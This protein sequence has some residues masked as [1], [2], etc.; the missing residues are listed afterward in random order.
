MSLK[1]GILSAIGNT[2]LVKLVKLGDKYPFT[3]YGKLELLNPGG[4]SKDRPA[5]RMIRYG[6]E[7]GQIKP[8]TVIVESSSGNMAISLA[9]ICAYINL[10]LICV[11]D[12]K[13][14][15]QN[16]KIMEAYG[17]K[18]EYV[19]APDPETGE[20]L[21]ARINRVKKLLQEIEGSYWPN[22]YENTHNASSHYHTTMREIA[23]ELMPVDYLFCAVSTCGTIRGCAEYVRDHGMWTQVVGV[24]AAGS[25]IFGGPQAKRMI[26]GLGAGF[27]PKQ[28]RRELVDHVVHVSD[29]DCVRGCR[30]LV[31]N[32]SILAGGSSGA[33]VTALDRMADH[34][35]PG[36]NVVLLLPDRGERYLDT[37]Y[38]D[39]WV[40]SQFGDVTL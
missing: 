35:D 40:K 31:R 25:A 15:N 18:I 14:T 19:G 37:I 23:A 22:Q 24:D 2:P 4:S 3:V 33:V 27:V 20:F 32:E 10:P 11:I 30:T 16:R 28:L 1:E 38:S 21:P 34:I 9:K 12:P 13:T 5:L 17:A 26:P 6:V 29:L 8:G 7:S 39:D 36:S